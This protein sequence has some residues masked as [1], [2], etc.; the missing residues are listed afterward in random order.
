MSANRR[1]VPALLASA[2]AL[3]ALGCTPSAPTNGPGTAAAE[4]IG[5]AEEPEP[6]Q[7]GDGYAS[8][9]ELQTFPPLEIPAESPKVLFIGDSITAGL[10]LP[11]DH[12]WPAALQRAL[13]ADG[14]PFRLQNAGVSGDTS[15]GGLRRTDWL[16]KGSPDIVVIELGPN[17]GLR[18]NDLQDTERNLRAIIEK[19]QA[20]GAQPVLIGMDVPTNLDEY[21]EEFSAIYPRLAADFDIPL[22]PSFFEGVGGHPDM[23]LRDGMHPTPT[24]HERLAQNAKDVLRVALAGR[25]GP[26]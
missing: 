8:E 5:T 7:L 18:G 20:A 23:N 19:V 11:A 21:A 6:T 10:H 3:I 4:A 2:F 14:L 12:A 1:R 15:A 16:L 17:D 9:V 25:A 22:V 13:Y 26:R 24:G